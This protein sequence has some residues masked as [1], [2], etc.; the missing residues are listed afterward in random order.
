MEINEARLLR[1]AEVLARVPVCRCKWYGGMKEG[2]F[3]KPIKFGKCSLWRST[4]IDL[5]CR[6]ERYEQ[7][8]EA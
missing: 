8:S 5:I 6:G 4:D 2:I 1:L 3:P 7:H